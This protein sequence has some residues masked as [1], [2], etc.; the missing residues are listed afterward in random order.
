[1]KRFLTTL[2]I[3][4]MLL[5]AAPFICGGAGTG[6]ESDGN[7]FTWIFLGLCALII[8][9]QVAPAVMRLMGLARDVKVQEPAAETQRK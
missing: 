8:V 4:W 1:M 6:R 2:G 7:L 9:L 3:L 5:P